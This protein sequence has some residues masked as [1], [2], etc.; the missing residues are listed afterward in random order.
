MRSTES[1]HLDGPFNMICPI[2]SVGV[3][4]LPVAIYPFRRNIDIS[5]RFPWLN[6]Q[7]QRT[8][9]IS[10]KGWS[11]STDLSVFSI[12]AVLPFAHLPI[13]CGIG[14]F[15]FLIHRNDRHVQEVILHTWPTHYLCAPQL[16]YL[17]GFY[18]I[19]ILLGILALKHAYHRTRRHQ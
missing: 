1:R 15:N 14:C 11:M 8:S 2:I 18:Q 9:A 19:A 12:F 7:S 17:F 16:Y 13:C 5:W 4:F 6:F 3:A 10:K